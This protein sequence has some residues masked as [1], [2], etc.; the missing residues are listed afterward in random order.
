MSL[1]KLQIN[2]QL[3]STLLH[4]AYA[5]EKASLNKLRTVILISLL[6]N[7]CFPLLFFNAN[8]TPCLNTA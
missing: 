8:D 2:S 1:K 6:V 5:I 7:A 4:I 3:P